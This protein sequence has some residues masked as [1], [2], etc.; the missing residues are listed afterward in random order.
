[1]NRRHILG[2]VL[3]LFMLTDLSA[4]TGGQRRDW[5]KIRLRNLRGEQAL[6]Q[7]NAMIDPAVLG[8]VQ[9]D[10]ARAEELIRA[11]EGGPADGNAPVHENATLTESEVR[12]ASGKITGSVYSACLLEYLTASAGHRDNYRAVREAA[13]NELRWMMTGFI[14]TADDELL[15][16]ILAGDISR[17]EW[18]YCTLEAFLSAVM[19]SSD[20]LRARIVAATAG[21]VVRDAA[22]TASPGEVR[23]I[24]IEKALAECSA[25]ITTSQISITRADLASSPSWQSVRARIGG[26]LSLMK[27][28]REMADT[29]GEYIAPVKLRTL[30]DETAGTER[31]IF[32]RAALRYFDRRNIDPAA[33]GALSGTGIFIKMPVNPDG[34]MLFRDLDEARRAAAASVRGGEDAAFFTAAGKN[35]SAIIDKYAAETS[36]GFLLGEERLQ[37]IR[38]D[39][40]GG[41]VANE[42]EFLQAKAVFADRMALVRGYALRSMR[43]LRW[44]SNG[45]S[46]DGGA[47]VAELKA[48]MA[49]NREYLAFADKLATDGES[50][51]ALRHP[52]LQRRYAIAA[53]NIEALLRAAGNSMS[54]DKNAAR[55]L[56]AAQ[57]GEVRALRAAFNDELKTARSVNGAR[58]SAFSKNVASLAKKEAGVSEAAEGRTANFE[59]MQM[60]KRIDEYSAVYSR[61]NYTDDALKRYA[62]LYGEMDAALSRGEKPGHFDEVIAKKTLLGLAGPFD[63]GAL[64]AERSTA[65][66]LR[67]EIAVEIARVLTLVNHYRRRGIE[68]HNPP[69]AEELA[70]KKT[71]L[72]DPPSVMVASWTMNGSNFEEIDRKA[73]HRLAGMYHRMLWQ[74]KRAPADAADGPAPSNER[75]AHGG[76][77]LV[78]AGWIES[79]PAGEE[80]AG[81][82]IRRFTSSDKSASITIARV[83]AGG[84]ML[85]EISARWAK[86]RGAGIVKQRWGK[87]E[88]MDYFWTLARSPGKNVME[89]YVLGEGEGAIV[90]SG[91][92][93]RDRYTAFK[94][95]LD[96]VFESMAR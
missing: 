9:S 14:G 20:G 85:N 84:R 46:L 6:L 55:F 57:Y 47:I 88:N 3:I 73:A 26:R 58:L 15:D 69:S 72:N 71:A 67:R 87:T 29:G 21:S 56:T 80:A 82:V 93:P 94:A 35:L 49:A 1:M 36:A 83:Q 91:L 79:E 65:A 33:G 92:T 42:K 18:Q 28:I 43:F 44:L 68:L 11:F 19:R 27:E 64:R 39:G 41:E 50:L 10:I 90:V 59:I 74:A 86:E 53:R 40:M 2:V 45:K 60:M 31:L 81:G 24:V 4:Y 52:V 48:R 8:L 70:E 30:L 66:Y 77:P 7:K 37:R 54:L 62:K 78:P 34:T 32:S 95:H 13:A 12:A 61:L 16:A 22:P 76:S 96:A 23:R 51:A 25:L 5:W 89:V 63:S 38:D 75:P 17:I